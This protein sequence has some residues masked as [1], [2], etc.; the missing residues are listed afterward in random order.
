MCSRLALDIPHV[1]AIWKLAETHLASTEKGEAFAL[2]IVK[3]SKF[4]Q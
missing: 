4:H 1:E 2:L 3:H